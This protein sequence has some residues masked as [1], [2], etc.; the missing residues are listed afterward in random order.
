ML[1]G[2]GVARVSS[3]L[4]SISP[5]TPANSQLLVDNFRL[6]ELSK[7]RQHLTS[8]A[9]PR[10]QSW[11]STEF[12]RMLLL[13]K[14]QPAIV[15]RNAVVQIAGRRLLHSIHGG[16]TE[17]GSAWWFRVQGACF[18]NILGHIRSDSQVRSSPNLPSLSKSPQ[19]PQSPTTA[20]N[21]AG[22]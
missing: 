21:N 16:S 22:F 11:D 9:N 17:V 18:D 4:I 20:N 3:H 14:Q 13:L 12:H 5:C 19:S 10:H 2:H 1:R 8:P 7:S 15:R 6:V